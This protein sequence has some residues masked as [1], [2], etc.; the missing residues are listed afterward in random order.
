MAGLLE[1]TKGNE[2]SVR[3]VMQ[4]QLGSARCGWL[5]TICGSRTY[6]WSLPG[7]MSD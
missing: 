1:S 4:M 7:V 3:C 2:S 6:G 5:R